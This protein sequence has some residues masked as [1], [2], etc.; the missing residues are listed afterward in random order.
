MGCR[1]GPTL[2]PPVVD[3][4]PGADIWRIGLDVDA[5]T[6]RL[7]TALL[8]ADERRRAADLRDRVAAQRFVAA[9]GALRTVLGGY[10]GVAGYALH[11][12]RGPNGKPAFAGPWRQWRWSLSRS[13]GHALLAVCLTGPVGVDLEE[14][15]DGTDAVPLAERFLPPDEAAVVA[16]HA[17]PAGQRAAYHRF[18][19]R[20]EACVKASGG[21][22]LEGLRL[23]V[24]VPGVVEGAGALAGQR[25]TLRD[26][27]APPGFVAALATTGDRPGRLRLF[28][29]DWSGR[30]E[31][32][33]VLPDQPPGERPGN[34][35]RFGHGSPVL[36]SGQRGNR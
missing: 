13:G 3:P 29:W 5:E 35:Y 32:A 14:I 21:R 23:S 28:E 19:S 4:P 31:G 25:W 17:D 18:L 12:A 8:D 36:S 6:T 33:A 34:P 15:R 10:L 2:L 11:W 26:L 16:G 1:A 24:L 9:H 20:K 30:A 22:F 7:V 27:P